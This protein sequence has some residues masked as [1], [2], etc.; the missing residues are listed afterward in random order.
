MNKPII[1]TISG[2]AVGLI[3]QIPDDL[4]TTL[5]QTLTAISIYFITSWFDKIKAKK[6]NP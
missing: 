2:S 5:F 3:E 1:A 6:K 4:I